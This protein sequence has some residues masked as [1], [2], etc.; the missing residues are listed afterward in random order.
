MTPPTVNFLSYNST[1]LDTIK[2]AW[3]R[4]I[5]KVTSTDFCSVQ[6]HFKKTVGSYFK[7]QFSNFSNYV[8][9]AVRNQDQDSGRAKGGLA[10][11]SSKKLK[12]KIV[13]IPTK[14]FRIQ[15]QVIIFPNTKLLWM[16]T[17]M[18]NDPLTIQ[19]DDEELNEILRE[20]ENV[21]DNSEF[22]DVIWAGDLN[23]DKSRTTGFS[24]RIKTFT[25]RLGFV[26]VWDTFPISY[27]HIHTDLKSTATLDHF[28]VNERL[29]SVI[30]DA[31]VMHLGDNLSRHSPIMLKL[32][33]GNIPVNA[34]VK[35]NSTRKPAWYKAEQGHKDEYTMELC[36]WPC[37][38]TKSEL[39]QS[40]L[41]R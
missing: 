2:S 41:S 15:A 13:R 28:L 25:E 40:S 9:P 33:I 32:A 20:V 22:D 16:N 8:V 5:S 17:Y 37:I 7:E 6:E 1:G 10:Q 19:F 14:S 26:S 18:P 24:E 38:S 3:I 35:G 4:D 27:T 21:L 34:K 29:L 39:Q 12:L 11:L 31:G 36:D 30:S 23:W